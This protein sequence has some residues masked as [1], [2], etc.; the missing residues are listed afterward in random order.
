MGWYSAH[1]GIFRIMTTYNDPLMRVM[2]TMMKMYAS[3]TIVHHFI[4]NRTMT[5]GVIK[6]KMMA[7]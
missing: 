7:S 2:M 6:N 5:V 1:N 4:Q 3:V